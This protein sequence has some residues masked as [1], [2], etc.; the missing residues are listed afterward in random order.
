MATNIEQG[1]GLITSKLAYVLAGVAVV[2]IGGAFFLGWMSGSNSYSRV[3]PGNRVGTTAPA[4]NPATA[5]S[6]QTPPASQPQWVT[7]A[8]HG[9]WQIRCQRPAEPGSL[10][11]A[12]LEITQKGTVIF[13]WVVANGK[14]GLVT[15]LESPTGVLIQSGLEVKLGDAL[16]RHVNFVS[17]TPQQCS[18]EMPMDEAVVKQMSAGDKAS[19]TIVAAD[20]RGIEFTMST[21]GFDK[22]LAAI[23]K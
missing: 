3:E 15:E 16:V 5:A 8:T 7:T 20:G 18:G 10:C 9:S 13:G 12:V 23:S 19:V 1:P 6:P 17:C 22:A 21:A 4:T 2:G 14:N 11:T